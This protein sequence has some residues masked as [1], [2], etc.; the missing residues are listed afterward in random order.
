MDSR[1]KGE[2]I[3]SQPILQLLSNPEKNVRALY[4]TVLNRYQ[5]STRRTYA[6]AW[7]DFA[8]YLGVP[9]PWDA[10][11]QLLSI[12]R[13]RATALVFEY[14]TSM[15]QRKP[16][17]L[18]PKTIVTRL[19]AIKSIISDFYTMGVTQWKLEI[20]MPKAEVFRDTTGADREVVLNALRELK[21]KTDTTSIRDMAIIALLY[22][23]G[24]RRNEV[25]TLDLSHVDMVRH[26]IWVLRKGKGDRTAVT[27]DPKVEAA[28]QRWISVRPRGDGPLFTNF[29][30]AGKG[31]GLTGNSIRR[32]THK[33]GL[34]R[35]HG[36]R[37][38]A[39]TRVAKLTKDP[40]AVKEFLGHADIR[41]SM[42]YIDRI[43]DVAGNAARL[44]GEE[45][46]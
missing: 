44:L 18:A 24:L 43:E 8:V 2:I 14:R 45:M 29:D 10:L 27:I 13:G 9:G 38:A 39:G 33:H 16:V 4:E 1:S 25:V 15:E 11:S 22:G 3:R 30:R 7:A 37:H 40:F 31:H 19:T 32:M 46:S 5:P 41:T 26:R 23:N 17:R 34:G 28:I 42:H 36:L 21:D 35:P 6:K 20:P 12:T